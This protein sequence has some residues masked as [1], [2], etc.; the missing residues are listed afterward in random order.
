MC[1]FSWSRRD[2]CPFGQWVR[3]TGES[4]TRSWL[5][6]KTFSPIRCCPSERTE[7]EGGE[8]KTAITVKTGIFAP[9]WQLWGDEREE[10][11]IWVKIK[12]Q[13]VK[14]HTKPKRITSFFIHRVKCIFR[15]GVSSRP[16]KSLDFTESAKHSNVPRVAALS[17]SCGPCARPTQT[18]LT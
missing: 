10:E 3:D 13:E 11:E 1:S 17:P 12:L 14:K 7:F 5:K 2:I 6:K 18:D 4:S 8:I 15:T 9:E 16:S